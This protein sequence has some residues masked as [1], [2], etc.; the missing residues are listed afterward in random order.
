MKW[1]DLLVVA[2]AFK[3]DTFGRSI[4]HVLIQG[5]TTNELKVFAQDARIPAQL[6]GSL[7]ARLKSPT[8]LIPNAD[9]FYSRHSA[10]V[11]QRREANPM[12]GR[13]IHQRIHLRRRL[14]GLTNTCCGLRMQYGDEDHYIDLQ[15]NPRA[16]RRGVA[17]VLQQH[18]TILCAEQA[19]LPPDRH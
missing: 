14:P 17:A 6:S 19:E 1:K 12:P 3:H 2:L 15:D 4:I 7:Q 10:R 5:C 11:G 16:P 8:L 13:R 9:H 18:A